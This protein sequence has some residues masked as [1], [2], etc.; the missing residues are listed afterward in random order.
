MLSD[1]RNDLPPLK[2]QIIN[3][4]ALELD[5]G[6]FD[7]QEFEIAKESSYYRHIPFRKIKI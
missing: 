4:I 6:N 5:D 1:I 2:E 7:K 3:I